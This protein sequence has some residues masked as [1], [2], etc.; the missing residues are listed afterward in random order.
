MKQIKTV[1]IELTTVCNSFCPSC[2]R[3]KEH[4][5]KIYLNP[6]VNLN[7]NISVDIIEKLCRS[8]LLSESPNWEFIG[9]AGD[10]LAHPNLFEILEKILELRPKSNFINIHTNGGIRD[11]EY[12]QKLALLLDNIENYRFCF[13]IDGLEDT[14]DIYRIGV[15]YQKVISNLESF[16]NAGGRATWQT[17]IFP[18]NQHQI[19]EMEKIAHAMGCTEFVTR[20]NNAPSLESALTLDIAHS[21]NFLKTTSIDPEL[22]PF[23][24][25][26]QMPEYTEIQDKCISAERIFIDPSANIFPCCWMSAAYYDHNTRGWVSNMYPQGHDWSNLNNHTL[27]EILA[28]NWW[29]NLEKNI[30]SDNPC[31]ICIMECGV[32]K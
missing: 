9:T 20:R 28:N 11:S 25:K 15:N 8:D 4:D 7:Q 6:Y 5:G 31:E 10:P 13:S 19:S 17:V 23:K 22:L 1:E 32:K 21:E 30:N 24:N 16:I 14:N 12:Y 3:Y 27:E 29:D 18:W 2:V 26:K